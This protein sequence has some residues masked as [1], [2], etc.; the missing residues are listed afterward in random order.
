MLSTSGSAR[1]GARLSPHSPRGP[2]NPTSP[3]LPLSKEGHEQSSPV[4]PR[5]LLGV[6]SC[7]SLL[8]SS[9]SCVLGVSPHGHCHAQTGRQLK[10]ATTNLGTGGLCVRVGVSQR[11]PSETAVLPS[12]HHDAL[13]CPP[14]QLGRSGVA[15]PS[16][17]ELSLLP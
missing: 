10:A 7:L 11:C 16:L 9:S 15:A 4:A 6:H 13:Q 3:R 12:D 2:R 5:V 1:A 8:M 17:P 14:A